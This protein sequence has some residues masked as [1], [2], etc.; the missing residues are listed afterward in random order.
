VQYNVQYEVKNIN[1]YK[2]IYKAQDTQSTKIAKRIGLCTRSGRPYR[3]LG[4][5]RS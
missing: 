2:C 1:M 5:R 3:Q 4:R